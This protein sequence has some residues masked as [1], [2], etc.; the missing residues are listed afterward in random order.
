MLALVSSFFR[1]IIIIYTYKHIT[2][3]CERRK[4]HSFLNY[5]LPVVLFLLSFSI[6]H[7]SPQLL[8]ILSI[9]LFTLYAFIMYKNKLNIVFVNSSISYVIYYVV[10]NILSLL[11]SLL[12]LLFF[13]INYEIHHPL[14]CLKQT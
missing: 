10:F 3:Q 5:L 7:L 9:P 11:V 13:L 14:P 2:V 1:T 4:E 12:Y 8:P 6:H